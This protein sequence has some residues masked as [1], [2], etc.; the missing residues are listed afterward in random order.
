[1]AQL[2]ATIGRQFAYALL[3]AVSPLEDSTLQRDLATLVAAE[4]LYQRGQ[5]P[6]AVYMFKHALIQEA[7]Y[8][9]LLKSV[10]RR[11]HQRIAQAL[12]TQFSETAATAPA[13]LAYHALRGELWDKALAY[14]R[15]AGEQA[16]ARLAHREAVTA[17][18]QALMALQHLPDSRDTLEQAIDLRLALRTALH[19]LGDFGRI[20]AYLR[21]AETLATALNDPRRLGWV[22]RSLS[23]Y[24]FQRGELDQ[25]IAASERALALATARG[26]VV[27]HALAKQSLGIAYAAQGDYRQAMDCY[28]QTLATLDGG[29]RRE[30][31]GQPI[32]PA[33]LSHVLLVECH[34][35]LGMF[36]EGRALGEEGLRIAEAVNH[37]ASLMF[38]YRGIGLLSLVQ[39]DLPRALSLLERAVGICQEADLLSWFPRLAAALGAAYALAGSVADAVPLLTQALEQNIAIESVPFEMHCSFRLGEAHLLAGRLEEAQALAERVLALT[40]ALQARGIEAYALWH[41][42]EIAARRA[43]PEH[44]QAKAHYQQALALTDTLGMRPLQ[45]HCHLG[46][47]TLYSQ[48]G[49][50]EEARAAL[51]TAID[52][53]HS[54]EMTFWLPQA[55]AMLAQTEEK[56]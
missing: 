23:G 1:L 18:E 50:L 27:L 20:M 30:R 53:Y 2:G 9:S 31:F 17:F 25:A 16:V 22:L 55:E 21:E 49:R 26:E 47:G 46:L 35:V 54:M 48:M 4:L 42:G 37:P 33:V 39:G 36:P 19:P 13:L 8:E 43:P 10:R 38:A 45:A 44:T 7:A 14:F 34:A 32:L 15:Q 40:R 5:P 11:S 51:S 56:S 3:R 28:R 24:F 52:L 6:Q 41:L 12:E 29:R